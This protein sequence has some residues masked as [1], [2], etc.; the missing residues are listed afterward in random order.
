MGR[1]DCPYLAVFRDADPD[2][3]RQARAGYGCA[4]GVAAM[5]AEQLVLCVNR[6]S[7]TPAISRNYCFDGARGQCGVW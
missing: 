7:D 1:T 3:A 4:A 6:Q 2:Q 5:R